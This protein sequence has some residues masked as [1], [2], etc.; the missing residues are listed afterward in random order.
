VRCGRGSCFKL[1]SSCVKQA[2][3]PRWDEPNIHIL[4]AHDH[5]V[6]FVEEG[7]VEGDD[8]V[9]MTPVHDLQFANYAPAHFLFRL[10]MDNLVS[11][12][13]MP[14][15][16]AGR[17]DN[18]TDL[19]RHDRVCRNVLDF[20]D[21]PAIASAEILDNFEVLRLQ[22][23]VELDADLQ[24]R[25]LVVV[26]PIRGAHA[27]ILGGRRRLRGRRLQSETLD[28]LA[29]HRARR[30]GGVSHDGQ[31]YGAESAPEESR[32]SGVET[33]VLPGLYEGV[34]ISLVPIASPDRMG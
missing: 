29:L 8:V 2:R 15:G 21:R 12:E 1:V 18:G 19:S 30:K 14:T 10:D 17:G 27:G 28:V 31:L 7:A 24:L 20:A 4:H 33:E 5:V 23:Q 32:P 13:T 11:G 34:S 26:F 9:G 25:I 16:A 6:V 3:G 22:I